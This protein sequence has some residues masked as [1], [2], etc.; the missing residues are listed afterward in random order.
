MSFEQWGAA[1]YAYAPYTELFN[2]TGMP[3]ISLPLCWAEVDGVT[4]P[5]GVQLVGRTAGE[6]TLISLAAQVEQARP[7]AHRR[8]PLW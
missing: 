3:A 7:W 6:Q 2:I 1:A 5:V 8:P 4:L